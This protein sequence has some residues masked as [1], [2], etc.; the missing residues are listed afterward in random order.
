MKKIAVLA[1]TLLFASYTFA[2]ST[3]AGKNIASALT[4]TNSDEFDIPGPNDAALS[5]FSEYEVVHISKLQKVV[6]KKRHEENQELHYII[7]VAYPQ[8][9]GKNL[10]AADKEFNQRMAKMI[11]N[12]TEQ[13][14][15]S[16]KQ[17]V[18][19]MKN[20]PEEIRNNNLNVDYD[21][22]VLHPLSLVSV[23]LTV[24]GM[25]A[26][27]AHPYHSHRVLNFDLAHNKELALS[28]LFKP[29]TNYLQTIADYSHKK[30]QETV[31]EKDKW[32]IK[33]GAMAVAKNYKNWN[34]E[35]EALL[36]TFDEYQV[37]PY[38]YGPQE[39][40]IPYSELQHLL[41]PQGEIISSI[42]DHTHNLG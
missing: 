25:L 18:P 27:R 19:N 4:E 39:V 24:E 13:F 40:E 36:I 11:N 16:V 32:M 15:R 5:D 23:R 30:L 38:V 2:G 37:A 41:S 8:I 28:D 3:L 35:K 9:E 14:K 12:E 17:N 7:D 10:S 42:K 20:L 22:D 34:I 29:K 1:V 31:H 6:P 26:G 33:N 21:M